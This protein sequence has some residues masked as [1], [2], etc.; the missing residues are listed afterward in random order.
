MYKISGKKPGRPFTL[1][2]FLYL[3]GVCLKGFPG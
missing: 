2:I 1:V 3:K